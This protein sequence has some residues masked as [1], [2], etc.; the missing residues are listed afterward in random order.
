[1]GGEHA[2]IDTNHAQGWQVSLLRCASTLLCLVVLAAC[3]N[4]ETIRTTETPPGVVQARIVALLPANLR[5]RD[6]W[7]TD[8]R[9]AFSAMKLAP[10]PDSLCAV[11]AVT[12][13][14]STFNAD[15]P[16]P[17]L[18]RIS[19]EEIDRRADRIGAPRVAVDLALGI[20]SPNGKTYAERLAKVRTERELSEMYEDFIAMVPLGAKL[21]AGYNPV[22]TGGPMQV[23]IAFA[24]QHAKARPYPYEDVASIRRE[25]FSRR[26]GLYFGIAHLLDYPANYDEMKYRF[27]DF[28]AGRWSSRN[29]AFQQAVASLAGEKLVLDGDLI[30]PGSSPRDPPGQTEAAVRML[31]EA[32]RMDA[33]AIRRDLA[34]GEAA[35][36]DRTE[37]HRGVF[38]LADARAAKRGGKPAPRAVYPGLDLKSPK[39][40]RKLTTAWFADRVEQR[41]RRCLARAQG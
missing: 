12:E 11:L 33:A 10:T 30:R 41:Y 36:F 39:I 14:E 38:A 35:D 25:I 34:R 15:P 28:N 32:L 20:T 29:A 23:S 1:M 5:G 8:I 26:G 21:A 17:N 16:V 37:L 40:T 22:R 9:T 19:R 2:T 6:G 24:E 7:A 4:D 31:G 13:Q 18:A 27:A 3:A